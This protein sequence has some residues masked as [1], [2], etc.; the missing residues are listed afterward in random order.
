M[1]TYTSS[2]VFVSLLGVPLG[3][4]SSVIWLNI[5]AI[6]A[7]IKKYKAISKKKEK[8]HEKVVL[9]EKIRLNSIIFSIS[10]V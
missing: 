2:S 1:N 6:S 3:I 10:S 9:L 7:G 8:N 4:M 5:C